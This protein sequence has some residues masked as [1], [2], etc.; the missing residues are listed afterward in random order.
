MSCTESVLSRRA[1]LL[2]QNYYFYS[3]WTYVP[4]CTVS[5]GGV[6]RHKGPVAMPAHIDRSASWLNA[7]AHRHVD[8]TQA[9]GVAGHVG[10]AEALVLGEAAQGPTSGVVASCRAMCHVSQQRGMPSTPAHLTLPRIGTL[11]DK[12]LSASGGDSSSLAQQSLL[13][14]HCLQ[15]RPPSPDDPALPPHLRMPLLQP[16]H[17][18]LSASTAAN[19]LTA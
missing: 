6:N 9:S 2:L 15:L 14:P 4:A 8:K 18:G 19:S 10:H 16:K 3:S 13:V 1:I 7:W 11:L 5:Q 12:V 17:P